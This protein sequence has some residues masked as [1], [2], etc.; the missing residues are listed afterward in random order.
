MQLATAS[1]REPVVTSQIVGLNNLLRW[2]NRF[3]KRLLDVVLGSMCLLIAAPVI[4]VGGL[5]VKLTSRGP[6][7]FAQQR[8]GVGGR[9]IP[10]W[11]LRT[12]I[13][14]A[15]QLLEESLAAN[16]PVRDA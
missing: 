7:F 1:S 13:Q 6:I 3:I 16:P 12:M 11:K 2:H 4:A 14:D 8:E 9:P 10:V 5:L 15:E